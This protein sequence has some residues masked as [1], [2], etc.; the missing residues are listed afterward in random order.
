MADKLLRKK[1]NLNH[2]TIQIEAA[3]SEYKYGNDLHL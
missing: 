2:L 1:F 3:N